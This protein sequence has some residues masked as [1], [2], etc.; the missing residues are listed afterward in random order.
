[1]NGIGAESFKKKK[2][3]PVEGEGR[4]PSNRGRVLAYPKN[5]GFDPQH[6]KINK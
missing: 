4:E 3:C 2:K 1:M 5:P 6:S